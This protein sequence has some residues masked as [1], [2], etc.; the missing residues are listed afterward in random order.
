[1]ESFVVVGGGGVGDGGGNNDDNEYN[2]SSCRNKAK[3]CPYFTNIN[4]TDANALA[5]IVARLDT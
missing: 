5:I 1:M 4:K 2:S 3:C